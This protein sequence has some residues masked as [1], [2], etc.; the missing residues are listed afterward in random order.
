MSTERSLK[1]ALEIVR[2]EHAAV[3]G[4]EVAVCCLTNVAPEL[5]APGYDP[6]T[7]VDPGQAGR[8]FVVDAKDCLI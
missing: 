8:E 4:V 2:D 1:K 6:K 7:C 5:G 3:H